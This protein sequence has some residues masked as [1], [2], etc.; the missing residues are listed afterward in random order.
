MI[1]KLKNVSL[2]SVMA[3]IMFSQAASSFDFLLRHGVTASDSLIQFTRQISQP[4]TIS[5]MTPVKRSSSLSEVKY[6]V[7]FVKKESR[8][9]I[10]FLSKPVGEYMTPDYLT[11]P[12]IKYVSIGGA[13]YIYPNRKS[14]S[15]G[16]QNGDSVT[17]AI[18]F[19]QNKVSF[20][21]NDKLVGTADWSPTNDNAYFSISC[22]PG[23]VLVEISQS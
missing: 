5:L 16:Y 8:T 14:A 2:H 15:R 7:K 18:D 4:L 11:D 23:D 22:E 19:Q 3:F 6:T 20:M 21:V 9:A 1:K 13:G 17:S 10:G 12:T